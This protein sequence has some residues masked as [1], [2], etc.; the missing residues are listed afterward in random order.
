MRDLFIAAVADDRGVGGAGREFD[1]AVSGSPAGHQPARGREEM[2]GCELE[3]LRRLADTSGTFAGRCRRLDQDVFKSLAREAIRTGK[4]TVSKSQRQLAEDAGTRQPTVSKS[5]RRLEEQDLLQRLSS[6]REQTAV[7][8]TADW[9]RESAS[10]YNPAP[11]GTS[12]ESLF[13]VAPAHPVF[14][15]GGLRGGHRLTYE[16]LSLYRRPIRAGWLVASR[17]RVSLPLPR[18]GWRRV[19]APTRR[20]G[21]RPKDI[22]SLTGQTADT[23]RAQLK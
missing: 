17:G 8:L 1:R 10:T 15:A 5:V 14:S 3:C 4:R 19:A 6:G 23:V 21:L 7:R 16:V 12:V 2:C 9:T 22:A 18:P 20:G 11:A 13:R